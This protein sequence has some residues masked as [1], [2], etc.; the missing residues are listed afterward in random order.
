MENQKETAAQEIRNLILEDVRLLSQANKELLR[1]SVMPELVE[2]ARENL[3][4]MVQCFEAI[5][6]HKRLFRPGSPK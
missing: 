3:K 6:L 4:V 2:Q 1:S 5:H